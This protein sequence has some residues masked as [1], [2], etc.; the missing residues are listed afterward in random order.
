MRD[1]AHPFPFSSLQTFCNPLYVGSLVPSYVL[2]AIAAVWAYM[3]SGG[4]V[5]NL[6]RFLLCKSPKWSFLW[7]L[8][9]EMGQGVLETEA[10]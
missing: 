2:M 4:S 5:Q 7:L 10:R 1:P 9:L 8:C 3:L 6:R